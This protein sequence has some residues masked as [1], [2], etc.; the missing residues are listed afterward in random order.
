MAGD[1]EA[2]VGAVVAKALDGD[3]TAARIVLDRLVPVRKGGPV[4][5]DLPVIQT[6][7]DLLTAQHVVIQAVAAGEVTAEEAAAVSSVL[8]GHRRMVETD[9][10]AARLQ[11]LEDRLGAGR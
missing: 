1:A 11:R 2:V 3:M 8:E 4:P 5:L 10:L 6:T 7:G 9:Q